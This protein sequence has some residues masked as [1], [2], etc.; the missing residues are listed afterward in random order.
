MKNDT[1]KFKG[2]ITFIIKDII[3]KLENILDDALTQGEEK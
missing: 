1:V 2:Q 3:S